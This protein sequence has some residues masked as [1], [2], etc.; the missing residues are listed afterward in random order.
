MYLFELSFFS[1]HIP[2]SG[3]AGSAG[4]SLF[5]FLRKLCTVLHSGCTNLHSHQRYRKLLF[6]PYLLQHFLF[7]D[8]LLMAI[9]T[10]MRWYIILLWICIYL[11]ISNVE[12]LFRCLLAIRISSLEKCLF[13]SLARLSTGLFIF[14]GC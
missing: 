8:F 4:N 7:V 1:R 2:R 3:N 10:N 14:C 12:R 5:S 11:I 6:S 9:L 13:T